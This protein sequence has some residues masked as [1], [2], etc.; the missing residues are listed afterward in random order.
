MNEC[1]E[2]RST[3]STCHVRKI[4]VLPLLGKQ[5][6]VDVAMGCMHSLSFQ[7]GGAKLLNKGKGSS[8]DEPIQQQI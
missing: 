8:S 1:R 4:S 3:D 7:H 2:K 5:E 6:E